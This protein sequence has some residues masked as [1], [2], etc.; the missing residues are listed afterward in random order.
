MTLCETCSRSEQP[1][2]FPTMPDDTWAIYDEYDAKLHGGFSTRDAAQAWLKDHLPY[3]VSSSEGAELARLATRY[4]VDLI[5]VEHPDIVVC[6][7]TI[8][9]YRVLVESD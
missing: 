1:K 3:I 9:E 5:R 4:E 2:R 7:A 6:P 8:T